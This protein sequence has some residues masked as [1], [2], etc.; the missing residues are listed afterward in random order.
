[1]KKLFSLLLALPLLTL[2]WSC[3][4]D[5]DN[6]PQVDISFN[7]ANATVSNGTVYVVKP[8]T[9]VLDGVLVK[10]TRPGHVATCVGPVNYWLDGYPQ[11]S[12]FL[13]PFGLDIY[14]E[15]LDL[16]IHTLTANMG[17]AEEGCSLATAVASIKIAVVADSTSIPV[18]AGGSGS[19][20][21][22][23]TFE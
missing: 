22:A 1:M 14:T 16:G 6:L 4:D 15:N 2:V 3:G 11:G 17:I 10:A 21:V 19:V 18:P 5:D 13:D 7:F 23:H 8:D 12:T 20:P 9:L